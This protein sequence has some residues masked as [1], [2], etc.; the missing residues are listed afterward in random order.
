MYQFGIFIQVVCAI[1][2]TSILVYLFI[3]GRRTKT[4]YSYM[5][6]IGLLLLWNLFEIPIELSRNASQEMIA[7]KLKF[8]PVVY[9]GACWFYFCLNITHSKLVDNKALKIFMIFFPAICYSF[10]LTNEWHG[11]FFSE[12]VF[13]TKIKKGLVFWIHTAESYFFIFSGAVYLFVHMRKKAGKSLKYVVLLLMAVMI[14]L[15]A[16][17]FTIMEMVPGSTDI[18]SQVFLLS[19]ILFGIAVYQKKF[20]NLYPVAARHFIETMTDGIIILDRENFVV[21]INDAV[22]NLLP[23]LD[24]KIYETEQK[25]IDYLGENCDKGFNN[26]PVLLKDESGFL[27]EKRKIKIQEKV[28]SIE[29]KTLADKYRNPSGKI[30][31]LEDFTEEQQLLDEIKKKNLLLTKANKRLTKSNYMLMD[32]NKRLEKMSNT[33]EELAIMKE[34]NRVGREVHDTV[35]H[36]L[37]LLIALAENAKLGLT[38]EQTNIKEALDKSIELSRQALN[39]I[40]NCLN[41]I[42]KEPFEKVSL[43]DLMNHLMKTNYTPGTRVEVSISE[44]LKELCAERMMAIYRICQESITNAIRHGNAKTVN[45]IIKNQMNTVRLYIF[46]DGIGCSNIVKGYGLTGMEERVAKLCGKISFGSD[47][48]KGFNIIAELPVC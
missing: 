36:M 18:T 13:K 29:V 32:A 39:D 26:E 43:V 15:A 3:S 40:R 2:A 46:D 19:F 45:I 8:I 5:A 24:L 30:I 47:G 38:D 12:V 17:I 16:N 28:I 20:L 31:I 33:I 37:T 25:I 27:P 35:G 11:L 41:D 14:P 34:R 23:G 4:T 10:L 48:E 9:I 22:N 1:L 7:L 21:G 6:C 44:N 42:C